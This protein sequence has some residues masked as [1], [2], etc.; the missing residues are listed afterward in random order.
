MKVLPGGIIRFAMPFDDERNAWKE[1]EL[2]EEK[3][4]YQEDDYEPRNPQAGGQV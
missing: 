3:T 2:D 4:D 1:V